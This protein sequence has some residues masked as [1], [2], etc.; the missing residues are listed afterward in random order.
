MFLP[1]ASDCELCH[2]GKGSSSRLFCLKARAARSYDLFCNSGKK[3]LKSADW[4]SRLTP[5]DFQYPLI[6]VAIFLDNWLLV[7]HIPS[8]NSISLSFT[9][10]SRIPSPSMS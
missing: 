5:I 3:D 4:I 9:G 2:R 1:A 10:H 7:V 6:R 8:V